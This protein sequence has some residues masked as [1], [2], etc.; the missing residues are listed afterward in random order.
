MKR[1]LTYVFILVLILLLPVPSLFARGIGKLPPL[2]FEQMYQMAAKGKKQAL[3]NAIYR[4]LNINAV[5]ADGDTGL[6]VAVKRKNVKAF[7]TFRAVGANVRHPCTQ[8]IPYYNTFI[9]KSAVR[10]AD[11]FAPN[12]AHRASNDKTNLFFWG[13]LAAGAGAGAYY[14]LKDDGG[15]ESD[16]C[17]SVTCP[18]NGHCEK[19]GCV[20]DN[21]YLNYEGACEEASSLCHEN[22]V[23]KNDKCECTGN[24]DPEKKCSECLKGFVFYEGYCVDEKK[25]CLN[26]G[27]Y[28][29]VLKRC[30]CQ[31]NFDSSTNCEKCETGYKLS[32]N[33]CVEIV[34]PTPPTPDCNP[35]NGHYDAGSQKCICTT[36]WDQANNC[37]ACASGYEYTGEKC[38]KP[39]DPLP[40]S[41]NCGSH[42]TW[43]S[44]QNKCVCQD[45]FNPETS[46]QTCLKEYELVKG[47]NSDTH[48]DT[49]VKKEDLCNKQ[50][51]WNEYKQEC[52]CNEGYKVKEDD[53]KTCE[54][55]TE[56]GPEAA[57]AVGILA[58]ED[59]DLSQ[60]GQQKDRALRLMALVRRIAVVQEQEAE[61]Y[62]IKAGGKVYDGAG[63]YVVDVQNKSQTKNAYGIEAGS[64]DLTKAS[65]QITVSGNA[66]VYGIKSRGET[67]NKW[68]VTVEVGG[69]GQGYGLYVVADEKNAAPKIENS[70]NIKLNGE[71]AKELIGI[72]AKNAELKNTGKIEINGGAET[73]AYGIYADNAN[74]YNNGE[75]VV[76][77]HAESYGIY[78][79]NNST[80]LNEGKITLNGKTCAG[81]NCQE[82][83]QIKLDES[84]VLKNNGLI[85]SDEALNLND[86]GQNVL[87]GKNGSFE[88]EK[89]SG[90]LGVASDVVMEGFKNQYVEEGA[91]KGGL[92]DLE[93]NS[94][95]AMFYATRRNGKE[96]G[97]Q[98]VVMTRKSFD[99]IAATNSIADYLE[100]N[101]SQEKNEELFKRLKE[102]PDTPAY[103]KAEA[104]ITG[105]S[106]LPNFSQENMRVFRNL[107]SVMEDELFEAEGKERKVVGYDYQYSKRDAKGTLTGYENKAN[108]MYFMYD[109]ELE[110]M[111]Y[112]GLGMSITRFQSDY[113]DGSERQEMMFSLLAPLGY[114]FENGFKTQSI[115]RLGYSNGKYSRQTS[116]GTFDADLSGVLYGI[117]NAFRYG[118]DL[119]MFTIEPQVEFNVLGYHQNRIREDKNK[120]L[121]IKADGA[122]NVSVESG[123][124]MYIKKNMRF[125]EISRLKMKI[126]G[127]W[128]H[129]FANPYQ[130]LRAR[131]RGMVGKYRLRDKTGIYNQ[132]RGVLKA[133]IE[134]D[135]RALTFYLIWRQ[136]ME[137]ENPM[138]L[139][140]GVKY[141]F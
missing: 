37:Y 47:A 92:E 96:E 104:E 16:P 91:L 94:Q 103:E 8:N 138:S 106:L 9:N 74:V 34:A 7:N 20:C 24:Y 62:G 75:I 36:G 50:G 15:G 99:Q 118:K 14:L 95:S 28:N 126:G 69:K 13:G 58:T 4:G 65:G 114:K 84:S 79:Q 135:W 53:K 29:D 93:L 10:E 26:G 121:S 124:G 51:D 113:E 100:T 109:K 86:I 45:N 139:N 132:N 141:K 17:A 3:F 31:N 116:N 87:L 72:Y 110:N 60:S 80:V 123:F 54:K 52:E 70:G 82:G 64:V 105:T 6:C 85:Q 11:F 137:D 83:G 38:I 131:H 101:Y 63:A 43:D 88:A 27:T 78:A 81:E 130:S 71:N 66:D 18:L 134:Y 56:A 61:A 42:G 117:S 30:I 39:S 98:D 35:P 140:A 68:D 73:K 111:L 40:P 67:L 90:T 22:G 23:W 122:N 44:A 19:G 107:N 112:A 77:G 2:Y 5:N 133:E 48:K 32:G 127:M 46:C 57:A 55:S 129:E 21:G 136:F 102:A 49:C 119:G 108:S 76:T 97:R 12:Y 25:L 125:S 120:A 1:F 115:L 128:Y 41:G 89:L 33:K 59:V